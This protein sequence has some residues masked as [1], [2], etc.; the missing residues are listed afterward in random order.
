MSGSRRNSTARAKATI[1]EE[2]RAEKTPVSGLTAREARPAPEPPA[3][4]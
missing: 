2:H 1:L 3:S 4:S